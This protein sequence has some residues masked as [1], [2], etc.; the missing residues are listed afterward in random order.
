MAKLTKAVALLLLAL[1]LFVLAQDTS[2]D[3][4][5]DVI[6]NPTPT[7]DPVV[8]T[9]VSVPA[10]STTNP[11]I[12]TTDP[13]YGDGVATN[14]IFQNLGTVGL[15]LSIT[16]SAQKFASLAA[17]L[18]DHNQKITFFAPADSALAASISSGDL[19]LTRTDNL[20]NILL[21][22]I[23]KGA[24]S[25]QNSGALVFLDSFFNNASFVRIGQNKPQVI[26]V[27]NESGNMKVND[28]AI[29]A[30]FIKKDIKCSNGFLHIVDKVLL[31]PINTLRTLSAIPELSTFYNILD[32]NN[33][34]GPVSG[35]ALTIFAPNNAAW[36]AYNYTSKPGGVLKME[37]KYHISNTGV[38][39]TLNFT[40]G[41]RLSAISGQL[42]VANVALNGTI[43]INGAPIVIGNILT[44]N[45]VVHVLGQVIDMSKIAY[46]NMSFTTNYLAPVS[47]LQSTI[48]PTSK[49]SAA[50][51]T[52]AWGIG[53]GA[54][55]AVA[56]VLV[57]L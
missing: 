36:A 27:T 33:V 49:T 37:V 9:S 44:S 31:P 15:Y 29:T 48:V 45:A 3:T 14:T 2:T 4:A 42:L 50:W 8:T 17:I 23:G 38:F 51:K 16:L 57:G 46:T 53:F 1:P 6:P 25:S 10:P 32:P 19:N 52:D 56:A 55:V 34:T 7:P 26:E 40:D 11:P 18:D 13:A 39:H 28:G 47:T 35:Q 5:S 12:P 24:I 43:F 22:H 54:T 41:Q 21:Y 20:T 30:N